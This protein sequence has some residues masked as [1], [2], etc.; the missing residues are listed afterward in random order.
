MTLNQKES[1]ESKA[2]RDLEEQ[3]II[4]AMHN[5]V[6]GEVVGHGFGLFVVNGEVTADKSRVSH[7]F[8]RECSCNAV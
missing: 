7:L 6:S 5:L 1:K 4:T 8:F 3:V 2:M